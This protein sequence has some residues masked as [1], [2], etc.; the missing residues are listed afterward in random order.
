MIREGWR[1]SWEA[2]TYSQWG[3]NPR[4]PHYEQFAILVQGPN[5][6]TARYHCAIG[7]QIENYHIVHNIY[8]L[9]QNLCFIILVDHHPEKDFLHIWVTYQCEQKDTRVLQQNPNL[10]ISQTPILLL[11]QTIMVSPNVQSSTQEIATR[12]PLNKKSLNTTR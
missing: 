2:K 8:F 10:T 11:Y 6:R 7:V 3:S 5:I 4:H 9:F 12:K 1:T